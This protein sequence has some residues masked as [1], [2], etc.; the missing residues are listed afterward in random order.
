MLLLPS[1]CLAVDTM[2]GGKPLFPNLTLRIAGVF[3]TAKRLSSPTAAVFPDWLADW[4]CV[5]ARGQN[6]LLTL[7][8]HLPSLQGLLG[9]L[10]IN[11][12]ELGEKH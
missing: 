8:C 12:A 10:H 2:L 6:H 3:S 1:Y 4:H 7:H 5:E 11:K 9:R